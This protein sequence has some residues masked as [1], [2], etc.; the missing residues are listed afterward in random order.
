MIYTKRHWVLFLLQNLLPIILILL[1]A[2]L[3]ETQNVKTPL[4]GLDI[5]LKTYDTSVTILEESQNVV[6]NSL[7]AKYGAVLLLFHIQFL[8]W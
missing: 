4:P 5:S 6:P 2:A 3:G 7:S 8:I 1:G